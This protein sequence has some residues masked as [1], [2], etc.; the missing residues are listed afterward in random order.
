VITTGTITT[1]ITIT[2]LI[3]VTTVSRGI[4]RTGNI[5]FLER[6]MQSVHT[7]TDTTDEGYIRSELKVVIYIFT[8]L[9]VASS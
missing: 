9:T 4:T 7:L 3:T 1:T 8:V 6:K 2:L 5:T